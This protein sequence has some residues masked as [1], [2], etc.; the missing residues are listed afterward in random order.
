MY[1]WEQS[2]LYVT[3][4][5]KGSSTD[6]NLDDPSG[7]SILVSNPLDPA[8]SRHRAFDPECASGVRRHRDSQGSL[9][10]PVFDVSARCGG[11]VVGPV[12]IVPEDTSGKDPL[13]KYLKA[14]TIH[15]PPENMPASSLVGDSPA[16]STESLQMDRVHLL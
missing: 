12:Q 11:T 4:R 9:Q 10:Q 3:L 14:T 2:K 15:F 5:T 13:P 16:P 6:K 7:L 1:R 8:R